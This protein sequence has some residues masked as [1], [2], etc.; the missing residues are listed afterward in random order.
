MIFLIGCG[1]NPERIVETRYPQIPS[2]YLEKCNK[3]FKDSTIQ[4]VLL[5]LDETIGCYEAKQD[6]LK[7]WYKELTEKDEE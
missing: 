4:S 1:S 6:N 5:G 7:T 2:V 3:D